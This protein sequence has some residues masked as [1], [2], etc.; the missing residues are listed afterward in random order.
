MVEVT[1]YGLPLDTLPEPVVEL[2]REVGRWL[3]VEPGSSLLFVMGEGYDGLGAGEYAL[4]SEGVRYPFAWNL[5]LA[6]LDGEV[7]V[8][9]A[10]TIR[11]MGSC[12]MGVYQRGCSCGE[13]DYGA[14]GHD[15]GP[16]VE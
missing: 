12:V 5:D 7:R 4:V 9:Q 16:A 1:G 6:V 15:G 10:L 2:A 8:P 3:E 13:A 14:P 11:A